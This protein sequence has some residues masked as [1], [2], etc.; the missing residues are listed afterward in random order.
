MK[1]VM[2]R[3]E[4]WLSVHSPLGQDLRH[5][6]KRNVNF[7]PY[8]MHISRPQGCMEEEAWDQAI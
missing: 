7:N 5:G 3:E 6:R 8:T 2:G 1:K 4:A